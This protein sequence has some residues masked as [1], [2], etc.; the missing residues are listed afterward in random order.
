MVVKKSSKPSSKK[1]SKKEKKGK[2]HRVMVSVMVWVEG[3]GGG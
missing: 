1:Q 3:E 2:G